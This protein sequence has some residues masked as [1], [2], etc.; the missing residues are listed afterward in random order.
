MSDPVFRRP[1]SVLVVVYTKALD[2][3]L[4]QRADLPDF[5]Q[6]VTGT[7]EPAELPVQTAHRELAEETGLAGLELVDCQTSNRYRINPHWASRYAPDV[8]HNTE[9]VFK[10]LLPSM[11]PIKLNPDEH[12]SHEWCQPEVAVQRCSSATNREAIIRFVNSGC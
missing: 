6:S 9:H 8:T 10:V 3:L 11:L 1:E 5:W 12:L 2:V 4:I 7:L